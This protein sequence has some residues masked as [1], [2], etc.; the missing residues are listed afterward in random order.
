LTIT[1]EAPGSPHTVALSG[2]GIQAAVSLSPASL[3]FGDQL[4]G[5]TSTGQSVTL[6]NSGTATLN[7]SGVILTGTNSGDFSRT[8]HC[9]ATLGAG[10]SCTLD[11]TFTP[12]AAGSRTATL[13]ISGDAPG[14]PHAVLLSGTGTGPGVSLAPPSLS[15]GNQLVGTTSASQ[16]VTLTNGGTAVL[17]ISGVTLTGT[18]SGDFSRTNHCA[19]TLGAGL[20]CT[21]D[22][23]FTP[24]AAGSRTATLSI[25]SDAPGSPHT[26][27]LTGT[28]TDFSLGV[29]S[30]SSTSATVNAG[31]TAT[32][33]LQ[34]TPTGFSGNVAFACTENITAATCSVTPTSVTLDGTNPADVRV[35]VTTTARSMVA[36]FIT[37]RAPLQ[38]PEQSR[39]PEGL[40]YM[41]L[42]SAMLVMVA[43]KSRRV[44]EQL[45]ATTLT[46]RRPEG[47]RYR[48][49]K[50]PAAWGL[51]AAMFAV[52]LWASCGGGGG[53]GGTTPPQQTGTPA[54]TY[55]VTATATS[56]GLTRS[57]GLTLT[58]N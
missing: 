35:S 41:L 34:V 57:T 5:T 36:P 38:G 3:S 14:S 42:V 8:N 55:T 39:R 12:I 22:V 53:G 7:I 45:C 44:R 27:S 6:T 15:F 47:L 25:S 17:N 21:L 49:A 16:T 30:G 29:S 13:S 51:S 37:H 40:R 33:N 26:L 54:G 20:S 11:V 9:A 50:R 31:Q 19:A 24:I 10:L 48:L 1:S 18:N 43:V 2:T 28:G 46:N 56:G 23:T 58:V 52:L 4:V 32:Y